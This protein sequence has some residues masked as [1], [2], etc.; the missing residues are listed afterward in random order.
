[1]EYNFIDSVVAEM[2]ICSL[3][4]V[5]IISFMARFRCLAVSLYPPVIQRGNN[6]QAIVFPEKDD[7][8]FLDCLREAKRKCHARLYAYVLMPNHVH[9]LQ[10][11]VR[12]GDLGCFMQSVG[13]R[14]VRYLHDVY[15]RS[16]TLWKGCFKSAVISRD[17]CVITRRRYSEL[18]PV[19]AGL[20]IHP[21]EYRWSSYHRRAL[22]QPD[23]LPDDDPWYASLAPT[24]HDR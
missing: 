3:L 14:C 19:C 6:R 18:N 9:L 20:V 4:G 11:P 1:M 10:E 5:A 8:V 24:A 23:D 15:H 2:R 13:Q 17:E 7:D 22:G 21:R 16:G 12:D